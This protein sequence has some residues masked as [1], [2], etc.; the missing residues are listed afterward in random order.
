[1]QL[2]HLI[3]FA[4]ISMVLLIGFN[5][6]NSSRHEQNRALIANGSLIV[7]TPLDAEANKASS[8]DASSQSLGEQ[9]KAIIDE[10]TIQVNQVQQAESQRLEQIKNDQ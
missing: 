10:A 9:P 6:V 7:E 4:L 1:M 3:V 5:I 8:A 2:K